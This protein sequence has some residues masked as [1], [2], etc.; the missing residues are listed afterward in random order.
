MATFIDDYSRHGVVYYLK[1]KDQCAAAFRKF[2]A[3]AENQTSERLLALHL[4]HPQDVNADGGYYVQ[5]LVAALAGEHFQTANLLRHNGADPDVRCENGINPLHAVASYG[6]FKVV[7]ILIEYNPAYINARDAAG[8]TPLL[9]ASSS[10]YSED[11]S[12]VRLLLEHG[13]DINVPSIIGWTPLHWA[14]YHEA[15]EVVRLLLEHGADVEVK[16]NDGKTALQVA[17]DIGLRGRD[18]IVELLR[19][20]GAK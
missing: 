7:R 15:L 13:A 19:E 20:H 10:H 3:W 8:W 2:L 16:N 17:A 14:S 6:N 1:T 12:V 11:G 9:W 4:E 5:P 18:K